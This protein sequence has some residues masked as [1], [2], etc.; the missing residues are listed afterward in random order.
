MIVIA[1][2]LATTSSHLFRRLMQDALI[3]TY[4][5]MQTFWRRRSPLTYISYNYS[6]IFNGGLC[7]AKL[8]C[9]AWITR[10]PSWACTWNN[11]FYFSCF[12]LNVFSF[13]ILIVLSLTIDF[14]IFSILQLIH[15]KWKFCCYSY[16]SLSFPLTRRHFLVS[17][18]APNPLPLAC[19][20]EVVYNYKCSFFLL[21]NPCQVIKYLQ[22]AKQHSTILS[23]HHQP[24][25]LF[26]LQY[27]NKMLC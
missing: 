19:Y 9:F 27:L 1:Y 16:S 12:I 11:L 22:K 10:S 25:C 14:F 20:I 17:S 15:H 23:S 13:L 21:D 18:Y 5:V 8:L 3:Y 7:W 26:S 24:L 4:A 6:F 2:K